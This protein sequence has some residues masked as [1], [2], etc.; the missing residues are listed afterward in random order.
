[1]VVVALLAA[2]APATTAPGQEFPRWRDLIDRHIAAGWEAR[3]L[4]PAPATGDAEFLRRVTLDLT[5]TIPSAGV[6]RQF[7]VDPAPDKR[8]RLVDRLLAS[9]ECARYLADVL[10]VMLL[11]RQYGQYAEQREWESYLHQSMEAGKAWDALVREI[12]ACDGSDPA[13]RGAMRFYTV[14]TVDSYRVLNPNAIARD[15][16]RLF[17]GV[18]LQCAQC[19][20]HPTIEDYRQADYHGLMAFVSRYYFVDVPREG[21]PQPLRMIAEKGEGEISF[22]SVFD[23]ADEARTA[24]P[25]LPG[26]AEV[27]DPP[28]LAAQYIV[29]PADGVLSV[30]AYSRRQALAAALTAPDNALFRRNLVNRVWGWMLGRGLVG[31]FDLHHAG[32]PASHPELLEALS[33]EFAAEGFDLRKLLREIALSRPYQLTSDWPAGGDRPPAEAFAVAE[34]RALRPEQLQ[35]GV[36]EATGTAELERQ[37]LAGR[38][39]PQPFIDRRTQWRTLLAQQY[40]RPPGLPDDQYESSLDQALFL[41]NNDLV[42]SAIRRQ[43]GNLVDR[44]AAIE[45]VGA[46]AGEFYWS[47]YTREPTAEETLIVADHLSAAAAAGVERGPALEELVWAAIAASEFRFNH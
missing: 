3:G 23:D 27:P 18:N 41:S 9:P 36:F 14:R 10:D 2:V 43:P 45:D 16:G 28:E 4:I 7:V 8:E 46:L 17:L 30:P 22:E 20:D 6:A 21:Q 29:A 12:I 38:A 44:L 26:Q 39:D 25:H 42:P 5:G 34:V 32:N 47:V 24:V 11:E 15:V 37:A 40:G 35:G 1:V 33:L 13:A 31:D 19:H